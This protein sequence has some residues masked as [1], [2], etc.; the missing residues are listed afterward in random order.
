MQ[1][2]TRYMSDVTIDRRPRRALLSDG[3]PLLITVAVAVLGGVAAWA[4]DWSSGAY[5]AVAVIAASAGGLMVSRRMVAE[6]RA[7]RTAAE[8]VAAVPGG[9][10]RAA[11]GA[12][13][14]LQVLVAL[15]GHSR[16]GKTQIADWVAGNQPDW[17][18]ASCGRYV[19]AA[20]KERGLPEDEREVTDK[21]GSDLVRQLG[22]KVFVDRVLASAEIPAGSRLLLV[23]DVY[24]EDVWEA[25]K[26]DRRAIAVQVK[27]LEADP[28]EESFLDR[29]AAKL[30]KDVH[31]ALQITGTGRDSEESGRELIAKVEESLASA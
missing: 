10:A 23:D 31:P 5:F 7:E 15:V 28:V 1:A 12:A 29:E 11:L 26:E 16:S 20:A 24:H 3:R 17:A 22:A 25:L 21:V 27:S 13:A 14:E 9:E 19:L 2:Y 30:L 8:G 18:R 4:L 6:A